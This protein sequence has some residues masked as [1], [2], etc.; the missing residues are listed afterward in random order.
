MGSSPLK[1]DSWGQTGVYQLRAR[2]VDNLNNSQPTTVP[3][4]SLGYL[5]NAV[6]NQQVTIV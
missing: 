2:A 3:Y 6:T 5:F 4:D 1:K